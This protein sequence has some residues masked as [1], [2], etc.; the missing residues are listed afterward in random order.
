MPKCSICNHAKKISI[1]RALIKGE[2][3]RAVAGRFDVTTSSLDRHR[4]KC[5]KVQMGRAAAREALDADSLLEDLLTLRASAVSL[6]RKAERESSWQGATSALNA[7]H[8]VTE[9]LAKMIGALEPDRT[10]VNVLQIDG[11][12]WPE[13]RGRILDALAEFPEARAAVLAALG[14]EPPRIESGDVIEAEFEALP[15]DDESRDGPKTQREQGSA[16][17]CLQNV[18]NSETEPADV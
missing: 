14:G 1:N 11:G 13:L 10:Q 2:S 3:L 4:R 12:A 16:S 15:P 7:A 9:T 18:C 17:A 6:M 8:R 5:L